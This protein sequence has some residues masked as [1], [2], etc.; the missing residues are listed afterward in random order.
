MNPSDHR[1]GLLER[2]AEGPVICAEGYLFEL[3]RRGYLQA[4]AF[5]PEVVLEHPEEVTQLHRQ[6]VHAGSDVVEAFTYY[7]HREKL[8]IIGK[9][10]L[11]EHINRQALA[12][13]REVAEESGA[14]FAGDICNTNVYESGDDGTYQQARSMFEEQVG[15]AV[16][17][18]VDFIIGE[19]FSY[20]G[21]ALIGLDVIKQT[22]LP[23]VITLGVHRAPETREGWSVP[24]ACKRLADAGADVV[25]L[26]CIRGPKTMLPLLQEIIPAVDVPVAAL[27]VP[28]RTHPE[29]PSFQSLRD[30][31]FED[32]PS[33][34]PFPTALDPFTCNRHEIAAFTREARDLGVGYF[35]VCCGA[36]PHHIRSMA[37][38]LGRTPP[39]SRYSA[40][41]SKHA[42]LGTDPTLRRQNVE[43]KSEL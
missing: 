21:E 7:A 18:G 15:W 19:T 23:A 42:F 11:L 22:G 3:E 4:G 39:A 27:P 6:F 5:V 1:P 32:F 17:A 30:P 38:A 37:E 20:A 14:L 29:E 9:E 13:A 25:G 40:D 43:Y 34:I 28:Y 24:E 41:M 35:G 26:N 8:R 33:G 36:S 10:E 2:L 16:E 31:A 12:L